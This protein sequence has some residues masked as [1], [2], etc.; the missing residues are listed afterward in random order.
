MLEGKLVILMATY[1]GSAYLSDQIASIIAQSYTG[2]TLLIRDDGSTDGTLDLIRDFAC[3]DSRINILSDEQGKKGASG[4][5]NALLLSAFN[6]DAAYFLLSDQD[7]VWAENKIEEQTHLIEELELKY[8]DKPILIHSDLS[9]VD[10][11]LV[12]I[13]GSFMRYQGIHH[14]GANSLDVLLTQNFV[15][16]CTVM[17]NRQLLDAALPTPEEVLMHDW[18]LALCAAVY[19]RIEYIDKPLVKYRQHD[20]NEVGAKSF[21]NYLNP[22]KTNWM[23][24]WIKGRDNLVLSMYQARIL[25]ERIKTCDPD[26][27][28]LQRI[29][30][31]SG[32]L[33]I[34]PL[35]RLIKLNA[36]GIHAQSK[37]RQALLLSRLL[38]SHSSKE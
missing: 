5:F 33:K 35:N 28:N 31:Y 16:G 13:H 15:T 8:P 10:E 6:S 38:F 27:K 26:N 23:A 12:N 14:E 21:K 3:R 4:N 19:G 17:I 2:W 29:E 18:W 9:V 36:L 37:L 1:N 11:S 34:S 30:A 32:L 20:S 22:F 7:D 24:H 25:A